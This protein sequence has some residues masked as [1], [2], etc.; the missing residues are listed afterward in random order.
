MTF[1]HTC[2]TGTNVYIVITF[3]NDEVE[4]SL[5]CTYTVLCYIF[6]YIYIGLMARRR[7]SPVGFFSAY[8]TQAKTLPD[9][10]ECLVVFCMLKANTGIVLFVSLLFVKYRYIP[11]NKT[12]QYMYK[13]NYAPLLISMY[14]LVSEVHVCLKVTLHVIGHLTSK[15]G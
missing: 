13:T 2:S 9:L 5:S 12:K 15:P 4:R 6:E 1:K 7:T 8:K 11:V 10:V 3:E 14:T